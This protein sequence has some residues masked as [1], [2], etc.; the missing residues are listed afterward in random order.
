M[1]YPF[2]VDIVWF[3]VHDLGD[4]VWVDKRHE[5]KSSGSRNEKNQELKARPLL[6]EIRRERER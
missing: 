6:R 3:G 2:G 4:A 1:A 5:A